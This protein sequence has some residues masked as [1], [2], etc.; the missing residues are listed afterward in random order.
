M[1]KTD[2]RVR[3][4]KTL[5]A[6]GLVQLMKKK[7][8]KEI[9]VKELSDIADINRGTFYLHYTDIY[10]LLKNIEDELFQE[11]NAILDRTLT[12]D[13]GKHDPE[14]TLREIFLLLHRNQDTARVM[15]SSHGDMAFVNR[16]KHLVQERICQFLKQTHNSGHHTYK[17]AFAVSG[18]IGVIEAWL[19][20]PDPQTPEEMANLCSHMLLKGLEL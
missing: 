11:F 17:E 12:G 7:D 18:C 15:M 16:L 5:L 8:I 20:R 4:T 13:P 10:D 1:E 2:R 9:S 6:N 19:N 14:T 3:R